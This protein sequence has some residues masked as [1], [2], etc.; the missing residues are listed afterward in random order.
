MRRSVC[1]VERLMLSNKLRLLLN[2]F[3]KANLEDGIMSDIHGDWVEYAV[4]SQEE[5]EGDEQEEGDDK[6][7]GRQLRFLNAFRVERERRN[8]HAV[9]GFAQEPRGPYG[10]CGRPYFG[11]MDRAQEI[12]SRQQI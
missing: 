11:H 8:F 2:H 6:E 10:C 12:K 3:K 5:S 4:E 9:N 1:N 7:A